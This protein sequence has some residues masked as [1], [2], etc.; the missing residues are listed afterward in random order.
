[1]AWASSCSGGQ[2][3]L[4]PHLMPHTKPHT[5]HQPSHQDEGGRHPGARQG[6]GP[7]APEQRGGAQGHQVATR[8]HHHCHPH[9]QH[10]DLS[11][12]IYKVELE[13]V[14]NSQVSAVEGP[15]G[16]LAP[17]RRSRRQVD[18]Y[19]QLTHSQTQASADADVA[20]RA[21]SRSPSYGSMGCAR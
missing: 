11:S 18:L 16:D 21:A 19:L 15:G 13:P 3:H 9:L 14:L 4:T 6:P 1:M 8:T 10:Y 20:N 7:D 17:R 2:P 5:T 12:I